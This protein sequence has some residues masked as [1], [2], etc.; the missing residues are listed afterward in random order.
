MLRRTQAGLLPI[1]FLVYHQQPRQ[2]SAETLRGPKDTSLSLTPSFASSRPP[3]SPPPAPTPPSPPPLLHPAP[4][5]PPPTLPHVPPPPQPPVTPL[6]PS[7]PPYPPHMAPPPPPSPPPPSPPPLPS[8]PPPPSPASPSTP[9]PAPPLLPTADPR[10]QRTALI[11]ARFNAAHPTNSLSEAGVLVHMID[12][13]EGHSASWRPCP[14][15]CRGCRPSR[16]EIRDRMSC[17]LI[18]I[19]NSTFILSTG[20]GQASPPCRHT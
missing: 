11:N 14:H 15:D 2:S 17:S 13:E 5:P 18:G 10:V 9:P 3:S 20:E 7:F 16:C 12:G 4:S 8:P 6:S 19:G 1:L